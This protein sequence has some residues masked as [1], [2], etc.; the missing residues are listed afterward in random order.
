MGLSAS[1]ARLMSLTSRL[2][3]LEFKAQRIQNDKIRLADMGQEASEEY[4]KALDKEVLK[5]YSG[6][7]ADG[8]SS[9]VDANMNNL[10]TYD[11]KV[12]STDKQRFVKDGAGNLLISNKVS[13]AYEN[14]HGDKETFLNNMGYSQLTPA[15]QFASVKTSSTSALS[16]DLTSTL[17]TIG[18]TPVTTYVPTTTSKTVKDLDSSV[19]DQLDSIASPLG[20]AKGT[21]S[22]L[23]GATSSAA[24]AEALQVGKVSVALNSVYTPL[25]NDYQSTSDS[26]LKEIYSIEL[27]KAQNAVKALSAG[28]ISSVISNLNEIN[29]IYRPEL[30]AGLYGKKNSYAQSSS[31]A[32]IL[33]QLLAKCIDCNLVGNGDQVL[34]GG[35]QTLS[36]FMSNLVRNNIITSS[37]AS[38]TASSDYK[39]YS[40][41]YSLAKANGYQIADSTGTFR[42]NNSKVITFNNL[43]A[44]VNENSP[45]WLKGQIDSGAIT[46]YQLNPSTNNY[47]SYNPAS[48]AS[49]LTTAIATA[50]DEAQ[51][52]DTLKKS[53]AT[54]LSGQ[55]GAIASSIGAVYGVLEALSNNPSFDSSQKGAIDTQKGYADSAQKM[56]LAGNIDSAKNSL[57]SIDISSLYT[58]LE[59]SKTTTE[60]VQTPVTTDV[61]SSTLS[62]AE[63]A[64]KLTSIG[65][66][67]GSISSSFTNDALKAYIDSKQ[68]AVTSLIG[69]L[70]GSTTVSSDSA[71]SIQ[72]VLSGISVDDI[73]SKI[74]GA[75]LSKDYSND[76][77]AISYYSNLFDELKEG[78]GAH[79]ELT[80]K[81]ME[82]SEWLSG[83]IQAG[84][85][86]LYEYDKTGG[87]KGTGDFVNIT[88]NSGDASLDMQPDKKDTAKAEAKYESTMAS[89]Q[90]KDKRFD[91]EL[92]SINTEHSAIQTEVD[93]VKKVIDKNIERSFKIFNA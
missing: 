55:T 21:L 91:L 6:T 28:D 40:K 14:S 36:T 37:V 46:T 82:S 7:G 33:P 18:S 56:I 77:S 78:N 81:Q 65:N 2:S 10:T 92:T 52:L 19:K 41:L 67:L 54:S 62:S 25:N 72:Q 58:T 3:D 29:V 30:I 13:T 61:Y 20:A 44:A 71:K 48:N 63:M 93:S 38:D 32:V 16:S 64:A 24:S 4:S 47:E 87:S 51:K 75:K 39:Y 42:E 90:A 15:E 8:K 76:A 26:G 22:G 49:N 5:L 9:Y 60:T 34:N 83:Q 43:P 11:G 53:N 73:S 1:Q 69:P 59:T 68:P 45:D 23:S 79:K 31:G 57:D 86:F 35:L 85:I 88:W 84:N 12:Q 66:D 74:D 80:D 50:K 89:I 27:N 17:S 70:S